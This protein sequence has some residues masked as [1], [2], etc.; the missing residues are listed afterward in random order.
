MS[1]TLVGYEWFSGV[2][3]PRNIGD[4]PHANVRDWRRRDLGRRCSGASF[5]LGAKQFTALDTGSA[6]LSSRS[7]CPSAGFE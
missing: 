3:A 4:K 1:N 2:V 5:R 6:E 7:Q